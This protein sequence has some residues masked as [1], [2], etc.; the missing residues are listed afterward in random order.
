MKLSIDLLKEIT[1]LKLVL[2]D[3]SVSMLTYHS[4]VVGMNSEILSYINRTFCSVSK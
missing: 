1:T 4:I 3:L 2:L